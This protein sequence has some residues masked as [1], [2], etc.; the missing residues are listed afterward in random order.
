MNASPPSSSRPANPPASAQPKI[1]TPIAGIPAILRSV[2]AFQAVPGLVA[3]RARHQPEP[4][5]RGRG[6]PG[7]GSVAGR[8]D[9]VSGGERRQD[10]VLAGLDAIDDAEIVVIHDGARPLVTPHLIQATI[11]AVRAGADAAVAAVPV[12]DTLKRDI[13]GESKR[14]IGQTSG[15]RR[16]RRRFV[17][18]GYARPW[19]TRTAAD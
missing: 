2:R 9:A 1:L 8:G 14:S 3:D 19:R 11:A 10:S 4:A 16:L 17:L 12:A 15:A 7:I 13:P 6:D 18:I 5:D